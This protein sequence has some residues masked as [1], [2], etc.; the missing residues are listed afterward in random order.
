MEDLVERMLQLASLE[1]RKSLEDIESVDIRDLLEN[2][3]RD[4]QVEI[5]N[6]GLNVGID[7]EAGIIV[8]GERFLIRQALSNLLQNAI[9][10]SPQSGEIRIVCARADHEIEVVISDQGP[11]IPDYA[12][13]RIFDRFYSLPRPGG[14]RKSTGLGLNFVKEAA[15]LHGGTLRIDRDN[16]V[17]RASIRIPISSLHTNFT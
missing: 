9:D 11:G 10:F 2:V 7:C 14:E 3:K 6:K 15:E 17:T 16:D 1:K 8:E 5:L 4:F 13:D 12:K